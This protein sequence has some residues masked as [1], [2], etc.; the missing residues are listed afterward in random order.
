MTTQPAGD[1]QPTVK[2][3]QSRTMTLR[4]L[5]MKTL[6]LIRHVRFQLNRQAHE[7]GMSDSEFSEEFLDPF[8][9]QIYADRHVLQMHRKARKEKL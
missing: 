2:P 6:D 3:L 9:E 8:E 7:D 5:Q 4:E 1:G